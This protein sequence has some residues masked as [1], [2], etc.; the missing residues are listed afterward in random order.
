[1]AGNKGSLASKISAQDAKMQKLEEQGKTG[2]K[3]YTR[4]QYL[5][6]SGMAVYRLVML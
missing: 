4:A 2:T 3:A 1:M 6:D 5:R